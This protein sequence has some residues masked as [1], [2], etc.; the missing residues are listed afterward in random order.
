MSFGWSAGDIFAAATLLWKVGKALNSA[1]GARQE[2][3][4]RAANLDAIQCQ[5]RQLGKVVGKYEIDGSFIEGNE[6]L[7][8]LDEA[9]VLGFR[10]VVIQLKNLVTKSKRSW[11]RERI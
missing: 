6:D 7:S 9:D 8:M 2:Y 3:Q 4:N 1:A 5:L 11:K 10:R